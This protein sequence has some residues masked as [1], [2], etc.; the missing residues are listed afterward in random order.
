MTDTRLRTALW[1]QWLGI[2]DL[3]WHLPYIRALAAQ[4]QG[5]QVVVI[6][7]PSTRAAELLSI[8]PCVSEVLIY[9]N[10]PRRNEHRRGQ[11]DGYTGMR[12]FIAE[13]KSLQLE[14]NLIFSNNVRY[15]YMSQQAGIPVRAGYGTKALQRLWLNQPPY[16]QPY[17]GPSS[18]VY[19]DASAFAQA[20][21]LV[22]GPVVPRI[23]LPSEWQQRHA[24]DLAPL[25]QPRLALSLGASDSRKDWGTTHFVELARRWIDAGGSVVAPG[26]GLETARLQVLQQVLGKTGQLLALQ[27]PSILDTLSLLA[28]CQWCVGNDTG[29]L[30]LAAALQ[31]PCLGLFGHTPPL[32][33][34]PLIAAVTAPGMAH[35]SV[36]AVWA[37][38]RD[39]LQALVSVASTRLS[40]AAAGSGSA[41][42]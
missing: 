11:H 38:A 26:G 34:D 25:R 22:G 37:Q 14:R 6:A 13:L 35:I 40:S 15:A 16:I 19:W 9:D 1:H 17:T 39:F 29:V 41:A 28:G 18:P 4:S 7:R 32:R 30:N 2:G 33:H 10:N 31:V 36:D 3:V 12:R 27:P 5:G 8:E 42:G 24:E 21:G 20:Q 23:Q